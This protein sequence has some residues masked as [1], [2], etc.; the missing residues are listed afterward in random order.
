MKKM[1]LCMATVL[2]T[3]GWL[4]AQ[5]VQGTVTMGA[6]YANQSYYKLSTSTETSVTGSSWD[7]A[8]YRMSSFSFGTRV[9]DHRGIK[10]YEA[11]INPD[12]W[13][14]IDVAN[15]AT[16]TQLYNSSTEWTV[17]AFDNA[18]YNS[19]NG[20]PLGY[21]WGEYNVATHHISGKAIFVLEYTNGT[22]RKFMIED[23]YGGYTFKYATWDGTTWGADTSYTLANSTNSD[24]IFNY[25]S[26]DT[27]AEVTVEPA[28][29]DWDFMFTKY[30]EDLMG[31]GSMMYSVTGV[32]HHPDIEV[33]Q[34][35][36]STSTDT[37]NLTYQSEINTIGYDWKSFTGTAYAVNSD[38][39]YYIKYADGTIYRL[40]F[41]TFEG[42]ST[43][44]TTFNYQD[45]TDIL[46]IEP[47]SAQVTF[48]LYPNPSYDKQVSIVYDINGN[49]S[50]SNKVSVYNITGAMVFEKEVDTNDGLHNNTLNLSSLNSGIYL[51]KFQS[52]DSSITK[53]LILN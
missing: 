36:E 6:G 34:N 42:S 27:D 11:S 1:L 9:N 23:F 29:T 32:L 45:V 16:W 48:G 37:A 3:G 12:D 10:V 35:D 17:G 39:A 26:F 49:M 13:S 43:G 47:V 53:K 46:A 8:F 5:E 24:K 15:A 22:Y 19:D 2:V 31:D 52:G 50:A 21:G 41:N 4:S 28:A 30:N 38:M 14:I 51:V 18:S 20:Y 33:A 7:I 44:I 40:V 25:Y